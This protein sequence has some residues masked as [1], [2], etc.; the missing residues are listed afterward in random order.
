[1]RSYSTRADVD[2]RFPNSRILKAI[3]LAAKPCREFT[4]N[5]A[6]YLSD[7]NRTLESDSLSWS[8]KNFGL[9]HNVAW[10]TESCSNYPWLCFIG[11]RRNCRGQ[12]EPAGVKPTS[13]QHGSSGGNCRN[14]N[15]RRYGGPDGSA[16]DSASLS[17]SWCGE[18]WRV[19]LQ[20]KTRR[21][22]HFRYT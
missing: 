21:N 19:P 18:H 8:W 17:T 2:I 13:R 12:F 15:V 10:F 5:P 14:C 6:A 11:G 7:V 16:F 22:L 3:T 9:R 4:H 20:Y 1:M